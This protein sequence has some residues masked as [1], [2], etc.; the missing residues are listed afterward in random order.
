MECDGQTLQGLVHGTDNHALLTLNFGLRLTEEDKNGKAFNA[1]YTDA[2]FT[3]I[4]AV[5]ADYDKTVTFSSV[6]P[7][8]GLDY[9]FND[10]SGANKG[11][12]DADALLLSFASYF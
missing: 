11:T 2:T 9:Q 12:N 5:T 1:G 8:L 4:N 10:D 3:T 6:A 7:R